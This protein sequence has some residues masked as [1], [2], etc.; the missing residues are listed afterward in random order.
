MIW[1]VEVLVRWEV[2]KREE[3]LVCNILIKDV[4]MEDARDDLVVESCSSR[5]S[6]FVQR[7]RIKV[8]FRWMIVDCLDGVGGWIEEDVETQG[9]N[10]DLM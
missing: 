2:E 6:I 7:V 4:W 1:M 8:L 3:S 10:N 5:S 9:E